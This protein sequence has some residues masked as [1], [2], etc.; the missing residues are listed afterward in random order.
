[1]KSTTV[2]IET[3][4]GIITAESAEGAEF[5][6]KELNKMR[7]RAR[8]RQLLYPGEGRQQMTALCKSFPSLAERAK[9]IDPWN[10]D[11]FLLWMLRGGGGSGCM[12]AARFVLQVWN[13]RS[14]WVACVRG[15]FKQRSPDPDDSPSAKA[16]YEGASRVLKEVRADLEDC[17]KSSAKEYGRPVRSITDSEVDKVVEEH[18][19]KF[20]PFNVTD[21][22][23]SWDEEHRKAFLTWCDNA[24]W[25]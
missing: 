2:V 24:F 21:A 5:I 15:A 1:M 3:P 23:S 25:P 7:H 10:V 14:D 16:L 12:H 6:K 11:H 8:V 13:G 9:G 19:E 17:E 20:K 22:I 4:E 18:L